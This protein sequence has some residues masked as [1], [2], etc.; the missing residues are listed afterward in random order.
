MKIVLTTFGS[1]GD[2]HPYIAVGIGL[3][4]RGHEVVLATHSLY[5]E[6]IETEGLGFHAV[7]PDL[8]DFG[9]PDELMRLVMDLRT[10][11]EYF[12]KKIATPYL[13]DSYD[14]L[15]EAVRGA[16]L[17]VTHPATYA[18]PLVAEKQGLLW[19]STVLQPLAFMS[20]YDPPVFPPVSPIVEFLPRLRGLGPGFHR[21]LF[22]LMR[23]R[24]AS[25]SAPIRKL[26][27]D[28]GLPPTDADPMLEGQH[29]PN[30][31]L[32]LF[33]PNAWRPAAGL[34]ST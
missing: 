10:G 30:L 19:A 15:S 26:R 23:F 33:S 34:A 29:S 24:V 18:G 31:V 7:R 27:A 12:V 9:D 11:T 16:D 28:L 8:M 25:W 6:K 3:R 14:D 5:R 21:G 1:F 2:L 4:E 22:S 13:R 17:L 20:A 32:A